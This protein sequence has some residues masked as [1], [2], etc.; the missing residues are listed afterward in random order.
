MA[1]LDTET[2]EFLEFSRVD[3]PD[4]AKLV[5][6]PCEG[7]FSYIDNHLI[8]FLFPNPGESARLKVDSNLIEIDYDDRV[9]LE[10]KSEA[11]NR[12]WI[13]RD[14]KIVFSFV[15]DR[16]VIDPPLGFHQMVYAAEEED[17]DF[18]LLIHNMC[19]ESDRRERVFGRVT[20]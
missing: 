5:K 17:F 18:L 11:Q 1:I 12:F 14:E 3:R 16:P 2:G 20:R 15:Y 4:L 6:T 10:K 9:L 13:Q 8:F 19:T 7:L